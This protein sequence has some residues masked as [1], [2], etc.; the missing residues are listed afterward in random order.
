MKQDNNKRAQEIIETARL[1][2]QFLA[3]MSHELR[4]PLNSIIGFSELLMD[5]LVGGLNEKQSHYLSII[6]SSGTH[7]LRLVNDILDF[8][9]LEAGMLEIFNEPTDLSLIVDDVLKAYS[10]LAERKGIKITV[11]IEPLETILTD[12]RKL[13]QIIDNLLSNA[14]KFTEKGDVTIKG[15]KIDDKLVVSVADTGIGIEEEE[16]KKVFDAFHQVDAST[17]RRYEGTGLGLALVKKLLEIQ[18]GSIDVASSPGKGSTFTI[19]LPFVKFEQP[20]VPAVAVE[21]E[22]KEKLPPP[23]NKPVLVVEDNQLAAN[24]M[25]VWLA[26]A[27]YKVEVASTG[28]EALRKAITLLPAA[29]TLDILLPEMDGWRVLH[30]LK[31]LPETKDIPIIVVS[32]VED[33]SFGLSLGAVDYMV[34]PVARLELLS[35]I[36]RLAQKGRKAHRVLV[37]DDNPA[38]ISLIEEMLKI[39]GYEV[40]KAASGVEGVKTARK[41]RPDLVVLDLMMPDLDGFD[42]MRLLESDEVTKGLPVILFTAKDLTEIDRANLS[43]NIRDIFTKAQLDRTSL[44]RKIGELLG[45]EV[46]ELK[47]Q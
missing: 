9:R 25:S 11:E 1:K 31:E 12:R 35:K 22:L 43:R 15:G 46:T 34:K 4:T 40:L 16:V 20:K 10:V 39:D 29:I 37:I 47:H 3:S 32:I 26:D 33:K 13:A 41:E 8:S 27:G 6:H 23:T 2:S 5:G 18:D 24:L 28:E 17:T 7:L 21:S 14:V 30:R 19:K 36:E 45:H 38:D 44:R 42:V